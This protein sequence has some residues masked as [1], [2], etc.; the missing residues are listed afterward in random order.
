MAGKS[1]SPVPTIDPSARVRDCTLGGYT[2]VCD[3]RRLD[4]DSFLAKYEARARSET[5]PT[6]ARGA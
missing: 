1:L 3:F 4:I 5:R 2:E 6:L